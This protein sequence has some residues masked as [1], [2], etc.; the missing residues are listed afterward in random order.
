M[1]YGTVGIRISDIEA[2]V[3]SLNLT[4]FN[5]SMVTDPETIIH[6]GYVQCG[7]SISNTITGYEYNYYELTVA[8]HTT[9]N[10]IW[11]SR[12]TDL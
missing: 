7:E 4:V 9:L 6:D 3:Y 10:F 5:I 12:R 1:K 2:T 11:T 8:E